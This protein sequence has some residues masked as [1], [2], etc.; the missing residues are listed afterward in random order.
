MHKKQKKILSI[1]FTQAKNNFEELTVLVQ[2][3]NN[4]KNTILTFNTFL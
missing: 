4:I 3:V 2:N 1:I